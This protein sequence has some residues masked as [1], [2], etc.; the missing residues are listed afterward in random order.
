MS[1][2]EWQLR[3]LHRQFEHTWRGVVSMASSVILLVVILLAVI[4]FLRFIPLG[5]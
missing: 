3:M 5:L 4:I 1:E 2:I